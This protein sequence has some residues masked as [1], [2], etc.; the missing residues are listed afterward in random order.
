[1]FDGQRFAIF[2]MFYPKIRQNDFTWCAQIVCCVIIKLKGSRTRLLL[3]LQLR[4]ALGLNLV[5]ALNLG[6]VV[7]NA[8]LLL[9][10]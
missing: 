6:L 10:L 3:L 8:G 1:M 5:V 9:L 4:L 7:G 2:A